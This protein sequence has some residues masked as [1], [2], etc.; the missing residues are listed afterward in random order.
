MFDSLSTAP[1][2]LLIPVFSGIIGWFTNVVAVKMMFRPTEF[3]GIPPFLGWQGIVPANAIRLAT[4][5]HQLVTAKLLDI[6]ELFK[7]FN[8]KELVESQDDQIANLTRRLITEK[9]E[10]NF[11]AMWSALSDPVREQ[12][13]KI[14]HEEIK[15][16]GIRVF[17]EA[18]ERVA[19][20]LDVEGIV[21]RAVQDDK[22]LM[23]RVFLTVGKAEFKFIEY[24]GLY[25]GF[26]FGIIQLFVWLAFPLEWILPAFGFAVGYAT[27]WMAIRLIFD[28]KEPVQVGPWKVQGLFHRRQKSI[29][30]EFATIMSRKMLSSE[31]IFHALSTGEFRT[32]LVRIVEREANGVMEKYKSNPMAAGLLANPAAAN[33]EVEIREA[34]EVELFKEGGLVYGFGDKADQIREILAE[35]MAVMKAE[36]YENVLRPAFRQDEWKLIVAGA[37]LGLGAGIAQFVW[38]FADVVNK[39]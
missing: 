20:V 14:A 25:F 10:A 23:S 5:G 15:N 24:S 16:L 12:V 36:D 31:N 26:L 33:I 7:S 34:V 21:V 39:G 9:A 2:Q 11:P 4:T 17:D 1:E 29:S 32:E 8:S 13:F 37:V 30:K 3:V 22:D 27:N 35:R 38:L 19:D 6:T 28:P 18:K